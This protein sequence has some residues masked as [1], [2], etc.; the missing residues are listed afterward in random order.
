MTDDLYQPTDD[1]DHPEEM[2][3]GFAGKSLIVHVEVTGDAN[4]IDDVRPLTVGSLERNEIVA[5]HAAL[6]ARDDNAYIYAATRYR[7]LGVTVVSACVAVGHPHLARAHVEFHDTRD[8][9]VEFKADCT[10]S[11][12]DVLK[13]VGRKLLT[14]LAEQ[15]LKEA[16]AQLKAQEERNVA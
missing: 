6:V 3:S 9:F 12:L 16:V 2:P 5:L 11:A 10:T 1:F 8:G 15:A 7:H 14:E 13:T 4:H